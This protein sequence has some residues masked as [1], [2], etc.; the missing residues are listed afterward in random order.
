VE[1]DIRPSH[2]LD[3]QRQVKEV[4]D[5]TLNFTQQRAWRPSIR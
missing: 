3:A 5:E 2:R 4:R 1:V